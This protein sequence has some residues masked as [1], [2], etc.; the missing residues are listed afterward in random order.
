MLRHHETYEVM[1]LT[2]VDVFDKLRRMH[3]SSMPLAR[4]PYKTPTRP[5][6]R[7]C[8]ACKFLRAGSQMMCKDRAV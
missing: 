7:L 2:A 5:P 1:E 8:M 3:L 6:K 4:S